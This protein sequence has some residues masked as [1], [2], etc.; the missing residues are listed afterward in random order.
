MT[1]NFE[2]SAPITISPETDALVEQEMAGQNADIKQ[3]TKALIEAI[4]K[5]AQSEIHTAQD[6][7]REAYLTAV[8]RARETIEETKLID[9]DRLE[10]SVQLIQQE[11]QKNWQSIADEIQRLGDRLT[12]AAKAAWNVL[13]QPKSSDS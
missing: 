11:A 2:S 12:E 3:E 5:R 10:Q 9:P 8:R 7:T 4:K 6:L 13:T 1:N